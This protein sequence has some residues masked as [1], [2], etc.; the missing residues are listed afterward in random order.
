MTS[1]SPFPTHNT[2]ADRTSVLVNGRSM[3]HLVLRSLALL[4]LIAVAMPA[5][6]KKF[7]CNGGDTACLIDAISAVNANGKA[8]TITLAA[9]IYT[10]T[11]AGSDGQTGLPVITGDL[12]IVGEG[13]ENTVIERSGAVPFRLF[14][15]SG[16]LSLQ[17]VTLRGGG[18]LI[19]GGGLFIAEGGCILSRGHLAI[20]DSIIT[21]CQA[22]DGAGVHAIEGT[23]VNSTIVGNTAGVRGGGLM[24][25]S[26]HV[27]N[28]TIESNAAL[29]GGGIDVDAFD[30]DNTT[31][32]NST[33]S[34]NSASR[35]SAVHVGPPPD[36][37]ILPP[38]TF[39]RNVTIEN[40]TIAENASRDV[41]FSGRALNTDQQGPTITVKDSILANNTPA[42]TAD[43]PTFAVTSLGFNLVGNAATCPQFLQSTDIQGVPHLASFVDDGTPGHGYFPLLP[44]SLAID[45]G[46]SIGHHSTTSDKP[47][48]N[49]PH[50]LKGDCPK[51]DQIGQRRVDRCDIGSIEFVADRVTIRQAR[52]DSREGVLFV[53]AGSSERD[54][55]NLAVSIEGCLADVPMLPLDRSFLLLTQPPCGV[56]DGAEVTVTSSAGGSATAQIR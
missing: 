3:R 53:S 4:A 26:L 35:G 16:D 22:R 48:G 38:Q 44:D 21:Q 45:A 24:G 20:T 23:I 29:F 37:P 8:N 6:A 18:G 39:T 50:A 15:V 52:F 46:G 49:R 14:S 43:C 17:G 30:G 1:S 42:A 27:E 34:R 36:A 25:G 9:G 54:G 5:E 41:P 11:A 55:V 51:F 7:S 47:G 31:I 40:S 10:L 56:L 28:T 13:A 32:V 33:L 2:A 19:T 12:T